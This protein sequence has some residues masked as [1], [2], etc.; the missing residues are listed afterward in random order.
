MNTDIDRIW[1]HLREI[2]SE[3]RC[4]E[5]AR[6][7]YCRRY[8]ERQL[9]DAGWDVQRM[10]FTARDSMLTAY[11]G[12]NLAA[13][14]PGDTGESARGDRRRLFVL[15]AHL[16]TKEDTPGADDNASAVATLLEVAR[17]LAGVPEFADATRRHV[18]PELVVFDLEEL[19]MLGGAYHAEVCRSLG[20]DLVGMVSLEMLGYCDHKP[21]SQSLP[22]GMEGQYSNTGD[23]IAVVGNQNSGSLLEAFANAFRR[24][25]GLPTETLQIPDNGNPLPPTRLSD[26]SP[27][28]DAGYPALMITDTSFMRNPHY[29]MP[30]DTLETLDRDFL[31]KVADGVLHA[32]LDLVRGE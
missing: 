6:L 26:H 19:G 15:G 27:F 11:N 30:T 18:T 14:L 29:H 23:F 17:I 16:D 25:P 12:I 31:H 20:R 7:E 5:S 9:T 3:P 8:C 28:W 13:R 10:P 22:P 2:A 24:V 32:V 21:G 4:A 1:N